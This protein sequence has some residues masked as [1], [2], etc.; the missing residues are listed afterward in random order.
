[1]K[2]K[3]ILFLCILILFFSAIVSCEKRRENCVSTNEFI[4]YY[5]EMYGTPY[6]ISEINIKNKSR[7]KENEPDYSRFLTE[8]EIEDGIHIRSYSFKNELLYVQVF[9]KEI[10]PNKWYVFYKNIN[11]LGAE[12]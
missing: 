8:R 12:Y 9:A 7:L 5:I 1:M 2:I 6:Y 10:T 4:E 11:M 3:R